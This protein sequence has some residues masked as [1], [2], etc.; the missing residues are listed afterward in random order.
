VWLGLFEAAD[1]EN[2][3]KTNVS[4]GDSILKLFSFPPSSL[5]VLFYL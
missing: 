3:N 1:P 2:A 4:Y 5:W